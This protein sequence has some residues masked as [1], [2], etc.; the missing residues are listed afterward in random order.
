MDWERAGIAPE[1]LPILIAGWHWAEDWYYR[2]LQ[3][4]TDPHR[5]MLRQVATLLKSLQDIGTL[6]DLIHDYNGRGKDRVRELGGE[7]GVMDMAYALR[8]EEIEGGI[9]AEVVE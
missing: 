7:A 3:D 9:P 1:T 6:G 5:E 2:W 8:L 4:D